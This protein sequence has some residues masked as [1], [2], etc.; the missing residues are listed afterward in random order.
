MTVAVLLQIAGRYLFSYSIDWAAETATFAQ[1]WMILLAAGLAMR[2]NLHVNVDILTTALPAAVLR[3]LVAIVA[4]F[5]LW[6]VGL[7]IVG[8]FA[9]IDAGRIQTS[10]VL[11][12]PMWIQYLSLPIG[13]SYFGLELLLAL[14][15]RWLDPK[16]VRTAVGSNAS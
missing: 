5:C 14:C 15:S 1:I 13:L 7:A 16:T 3:V 10:P 4:V 12:L 11:Q 8:S 9:L 2:D 6:F